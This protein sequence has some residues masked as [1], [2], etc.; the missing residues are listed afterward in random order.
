[1][2]AIITQNRGRRLSYHHVRKKNINSMATFGKAIFSK[3]LL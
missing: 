1:M 2:E 3:T